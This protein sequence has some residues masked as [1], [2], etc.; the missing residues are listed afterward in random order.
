MHFVS[1][2]PETWLRAFIQ[3]SLVCCFKP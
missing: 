2:K 1:P 3:P